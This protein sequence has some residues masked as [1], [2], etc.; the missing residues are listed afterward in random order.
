MNVR[1]Q[2]AG[3]M[4]E[5]V[6]KRLAGRRLLEF[7]DEGQA[8]QLIQRL[9]VENFHAEDKL[10]ADARAIMMDHAKEIRDSASDYHRVF[11]MVKGKLARDRGFVL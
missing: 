5:A 2:L 7:R 4:A 3:R 6:V 8:R 9:L 10:E 1:D 11:L